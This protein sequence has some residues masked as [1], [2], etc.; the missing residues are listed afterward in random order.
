MGGGNVSK[1]FYLIK[2]GKVKV[3]FSGNHTESGGTFNFNVTDNSVI[4]EDVNINKY[5]NLFCYYYAPLNSENRFSDLIVGIYQ[6]NTQTA[7]NR[8]S[9]KTQWA[10]LRIDISALNSWCDIRLNTDIGATIQ[11][12][13]LWLSK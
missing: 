3:G 1:K 13:N 10:T 9:Y 7:Y 5:N 12:K 8:G 4:S 6:N 2:D 11:I